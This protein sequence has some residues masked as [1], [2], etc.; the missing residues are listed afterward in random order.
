MNVSIQ[1]HTPQS[2]SLLSLHPLPLDTEL[3]R[4]QWRCLCVFFKIK[5]YS[6]EMRVVSLA[7]CKGAFTPKAIFFSAWPKTREFTRSTVHRVQVISVEMLREGRGLSPCLVSIKTVI[8]S[9][10]HQ[11]NSPLVLLY[12]CCGRPTH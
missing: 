6:V 12:T 1:R 5:V 11:N 8:I 10:I 4:V 2:V 7:D 3:H 9:F